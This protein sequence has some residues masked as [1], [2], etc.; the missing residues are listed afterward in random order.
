MRIR[1]F[2]SDSRMSR[3]WLPS[4]AF[5]VCS[6]SGEVLLTLSGDQVSKIVA[7]YVMQAH[8]V[9]SLADKITEPIRRDLYPARRLVGQHKALVGRP[10]PKP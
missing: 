10:L 7:Q 4:D 6:D 5:D 3:Y 1:H 2:P 8:T 9:L